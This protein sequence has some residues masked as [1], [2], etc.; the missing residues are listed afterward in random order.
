[1]SELAHDSRVASGR[2]WRWRRRHGSGPKRRPTSTDCPHGVRRNSWP[3]LAWC[4]RPRA[5]SLF[6]RPYSISPCSLRWSPNWRP[7][8]SWP[9]LTRARTSAPLEPRHVRCGSTALCRAPR[10]RHGCASRCRRPR[11]SQRPRRLLLQRRP[12]AAAPPRK[13]REGRRP[14]RRRRRLPYCGACPTGVPAPTLARP[15][16]PSPAPARRS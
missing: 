1:M 15:P 5:P 9:G 4:G 16:P 12:R 8:S 7:T 14:R 13:R 11:T 3:I 10:R 6:L 2:R